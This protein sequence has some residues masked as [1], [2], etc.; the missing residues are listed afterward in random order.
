M[1][2]PEEY[3]FLGAILKSLVKNHF[4]TP[5]LTLTRSGINEFTHANIVLTSLT[6]QPRKLFRHKDLG[7]SI[8]FHEF[9]LREIGV[10][11]R[12]W[13]RDNFLLVSRD[14]DDISLEFRNL[15][16]LLGKNTRLLVC[17]MPSNPLSN[18]NSKY[19]LFDKATFKEIADVNQREMNVMLDGLATERI[20]EVVDLN[21]LSTHLGTASSYPDGIHM[22][23]AL[24]NAF[25]NEL[26]RIII[27]G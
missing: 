10:A 26:A 20:L 27:K 16:K 25:V 3:I 4:L 22:S 7:Y 15:S 6:A 13:L 2:K 12:K 14:P 1:P 11:T 24:E 23:G 18:F 19:D 8:A 21:F 9:R 17:N 5:S